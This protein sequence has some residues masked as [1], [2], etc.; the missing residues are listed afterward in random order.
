MKDD[1]IPA[2]KEAEKH[3]IKVFERKPR[4]QDPI[5]LSQYLHSNTDEEAKL[6]EL[7]EDAGISDEYIYAFGKTL[8]PLFSN[9][10]DVAPY[11]YIDN[12]KK[13]ID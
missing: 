12:Y 10:L 9:N 4:P 11:G 1:V 3:F 13:A 5:F 6:I 8:V 7:M 2:L